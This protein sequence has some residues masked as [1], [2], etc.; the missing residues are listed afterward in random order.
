MLIQP[1]TTPFRLT[2]NIQD[3]ITPAGTEGLLTASMVA[4]GRGLCEPE[5]KSNLRRFGLIT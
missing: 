1:E 4:I 2:P 5:V 3:F